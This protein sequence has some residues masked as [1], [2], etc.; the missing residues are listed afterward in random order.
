MDT[1][2]YIWIGAIVIFLVAEAATPQ[3]TTIWFA[4]GSLGALIAALVGMELWLQLAVFVVLS[5]VLL[6]LTRPL[7]K[8]FLN[9]KNEKTNADRLIG[10]TAIVTEE[11]NNLLAV[12]E[13]K[14]SG[15]MW[16]ARA[17]YEEIIP[18][19]EKVEIVRIDG[20][21]LIVSREKH[22]RLNQKAAA[23]I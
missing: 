4:I 21:K 9:P 8:K 2:I 12:G 15:Q 11:I 10:T 5:L 17:E 22:E 13:V 16:T 14:A 20:V 18:I 7:V 1:M 19:G 6:A 3:L 23:E